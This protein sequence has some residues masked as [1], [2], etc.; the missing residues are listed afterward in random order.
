[1]FAKKVPRKEK[2]MLKKIIFLKKYIIK[3]L[4]IFKLFNFYI[5]ELNQVK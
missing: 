4:R 5:K 3:N 2:K 1:M